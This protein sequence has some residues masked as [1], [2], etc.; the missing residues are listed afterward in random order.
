[1]IISSRARRSMIWAIRSKPFWAAKRETMPITG[2]LGSALVMPKAASRSC[3]HLAL[4]DKIL[5]RILRGDELVGLRT[6]LV[7]VHAVQDSGHGR[8][9]V[10]QHAFQAEAKFRG[11]DFLAVLPADGGDEVGKYQRALQEI[12]LAEEFHLGD[13]EQVPGQREQRQSVGREQSLISHVVNGEDGADVAEGWVFGVL[14]A[15]QNGDE[16]GLPVVAVKNLRHAQNF[17]SFQHGAGEQREALG[18]VGI[19]AGRK[20]RRARRDRK[21]ADTRRS[22]M[23]DTGLAAAADHRAEAVVVVEGNGD[24]ADHGAGVSELGLAVARA[25]RR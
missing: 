24:A 5:R 20:C 18:V 2:S 9:A 13:G 10:A 22:R 19:V 8:S 17:R 3:L 21:T 23:V 12:H 25:G 14:R 4:P 6:P 16:R 1:M 11:L 7:V 15:Q